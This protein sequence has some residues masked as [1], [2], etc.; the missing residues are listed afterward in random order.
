M[1]QSLRQIKS[2]IRSIEN[3]KKVTRAMEMVSLAKLRPIE[4]ELRAAQDY[5]RR[6]KQLLDRVVS[7]KREKDKVSHPF[8]RKRPE[9]KK[10]CLCLV[11]SDTGLC[12]GYNHAVIGAAE[13]FLARQR[14]GPCVSLAIVGRK[15]YNYFRKKAVPIIFSFTELRGRFS[16]KAS[17][18]L[19]SFLTRAFLENEADRVHIAY[20]HFESVSR[21][22]P[23]VEKFLEIDIP[24]EAEGDYL[25]EPDADG[26]LAELLPFY[27]ASKMRTVLMEALVVEHSCRVMAMGQATDNAKELLDGLVLTRNK[28]RQEHITRE[29]MEIIS[30]TEALKRG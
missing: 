21:Y 27:V 14:G 1:G 30:S 19:T 3:I 11:T 18:D 20:A 26:V 23:L 2:R 10:I 7:S 15:G 28:V 12:G 25:F 22:R 24:P 6:L 16:E 8:F 9:A 13:E 29:I 4:G 5:L 17:R